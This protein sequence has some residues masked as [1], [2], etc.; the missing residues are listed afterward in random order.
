M[1]GSQ[2]QD[3]RLLV[4]GVGE[5]R[6]GGGPCMS[7]PWKDQHRETAR[8]HTKYCPA[9]EK[10]YIFAAKSVYSYDVVIS[11]SYSYHSKVSGG[12]YTH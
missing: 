2:R 8:C 7:K 10:R 12:F 9:I 5:V 1:A 4:G 6:K 3:C 11:C